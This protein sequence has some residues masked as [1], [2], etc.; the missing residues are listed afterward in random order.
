MLIPILSDGNY[1]PFISLDSTPSINNVALTP[2]LDA[3]SENITIP[4]QFIFG[5]KSFLS[6]FV[7]QLS[8][9]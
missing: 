4:E 7:S 3:M 1:L 2:A 9:N 6:L 8:N 5:A